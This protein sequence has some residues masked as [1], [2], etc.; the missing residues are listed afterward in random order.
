MLCVLN[1]HKTLSTLAVSS[2]NVFFDISLR[3]GNFFFCLL[4]NTSAISSIMATSCSSRLPISLSASNAVKIS[5]TAS[6]KLLL[7]SSALLSLPCNYHFQLSSFSVLLSLTQ[8]S[9]YFCK[10]FLPGQL[11]FVLIPKTYLNSTIN[12]ACTSL[13]LGSLNR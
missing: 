5:L 6:P 2:N 1:L 4:S 13:T 7:V 8:S 9:N 3:A 11:V 12:L 10:E